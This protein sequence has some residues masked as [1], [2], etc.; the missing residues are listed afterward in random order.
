MCMVMCLVF[1]SELRKF[2]T[3]WFCF[4]RFF[5]VQRNSCARKCT[6]WTS[7]SRN[8][9]ENLIP[10]DMTPFNIV[11]LSPMRGT[12]LLCVTLS[13]HHSKI[14]P[15]CDII[16]VSCHGSS[17]PFSTRPCPPTLICALGGFSARERAFTEDDLEKR[18][19]WGSFSFP[20]CFAW[21]TERGDKNQI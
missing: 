1:K 6:L 8:I 11:C 13:P 5:E 9:K 4:F 21:G 14:K 18:Q 16:T 3:R 7:L 20:A 15:D 10:H 17:P 12:P 19:A 2:R